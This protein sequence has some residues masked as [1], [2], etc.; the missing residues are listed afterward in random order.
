MDSLLLFSLLVLMCSIVGA[1]Q[2]R[3]TRRSNRL[4]ETAEVLVK[5]QDDR[6]AVLEA[7]LEK[8]LAT[9]KI[10]VIAIDSA[11]SVFTATDS[12]EPTLSIIDKN[13]TCDLVRNETISVT[14]ASNDSSSSSTKS[15][16]C[17]CD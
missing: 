15:K 1:V 12:T 8:A 2:Y 17:C 10:P 13:P 6:I 14:L 5:L 7:L 9:N 11:P 16:S 4:I 3:C